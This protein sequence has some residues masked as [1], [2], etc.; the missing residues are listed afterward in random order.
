MLG[1][2]Q[3]LS[4][5]VIN[6]GLSTM[7]QQERVSCGQDAGRAWDI[8]VATEPSVDSSRVSKASAGSWTPTGTARVRVDLALTAGAGAAGESFPSHTQA[9]RR[10]CLPHTFSDASERLAAREGLPASS[11]GPSC[12][13]RGKA[14]SPARL[15]LGAP[16]LKLLGSHRW[17]PFQK[18]TPHR[19]QG[20][21]WV[22]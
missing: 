4:S 12:C 1:K 8:R 17:E 7:P 14:L 13:W 9:T 10:A 19:L 22:L 20:R 5:S 16:L 6:D 11:P 18:C 21:V 3:D 2:R 15:A